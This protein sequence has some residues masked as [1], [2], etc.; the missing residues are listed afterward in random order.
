M[1]VLW[2]FR[3][4][5]FG[6]RS[7]GIG[8]FCRLMVKAIIDADTEKKCDIYIWGNRAH[9]PSD[10]AGYASHWIP[11]KKGTWKSDLLFIPYIIIR[12]RIQL[13]HYWVAMGPIFRI[14]M[15]LFHPCATCVTIHDL[16]V[17]HV[18]DHDFL[19]HVRRTR[20][21]RFQKMLLRG[22]DASVCNSQKTKGEVLAFST[23]GKPDRCKVIYAPMGA[24]AL[25]NPGS[26]RMR[27][28][29]TLGGAP[30]KN[31]RAVKQA[32]SLFAKAHP[33]YRLVVLGNGE[34]AE[35]EKTAEIQEN[36]TRQRD[37]IVFEGMDR[38]PFY[39]DNAAGLAACS[40]YEGL[41]IPPLEAMSHSCPVI[42]SD[43][44][45]F[46]ETCGDAARFVDP[47]DI[48]AIAAGMSDVAEHQD[49]WVKKSQ[50]GFER[51]KKM[52]DGAG[53]RWI[54]LYKSL[55]TKRMKVYQP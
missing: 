2:D 11:Y 5:S 43:I 48:S 15:G 20:Y 10:L 13:F 31:V 12:Y 9:V 34:A 3:L 47:H 19:A 23:K 21:W 44:A 41:G 6:Y 24:P 51:Y 49:E 40:T 55:C 45:V 1:R 54:E 38:Y 35:A 33:G 14:G 26:E 4:F 27:M 22:A 17:E 25:Q 32:F 29:V 46:H 30:H 16:G 50:Q 39:L 28:F 36:H 37:D 18:D 8:V 53:K 52:S 7:R 42:A